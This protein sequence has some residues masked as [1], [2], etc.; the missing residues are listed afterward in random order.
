MNKTIHIGGVP[1]HFNLPWQR[2]F[3][4]SVAARLGFRF[5][6]QD[7][8]AGT[9]EM[10][11][12]LDANELDLAVVLTEG[13]VRHA[14]A[15][16]T[17]RIVGT[18]TRTPLVWGIHTAADSEFDDVA[19]LSEARFAVSR[20]GSGSHV[21]AHLLAREHGWA[22]PSWVVVDTFEGGREALENGTADAFLWEKTMSLPR[23]HAGEW[24]RLGDFRAPWPAFLVAASPGRVA[25]RMPWLGPLLGEVQ[26]TALELKRDEDST[27]ATMGA[28]FGIDAPDARSWLNATE[29][30]AST[31]VDQVMLL[32]VAETLRTAGVGAE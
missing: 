1:E 3:A 18:Y 24:R 7:V 22:E 2:A 6:W 10:V 14:E 31:Q 27:I 8:P 20:F 17:A 25:Q 11:R 21:I 29:W 15:G 32:R 16:G 30:D 12:M 26:R 19:S 28:R 9:G 5:V 4:T 13:M 23:V